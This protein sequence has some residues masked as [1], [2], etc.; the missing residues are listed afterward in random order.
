MNKDKLLIL[1]ER[2]L[3]NEATADEIKEIDAW[4][5]QFDHE[6]DLDPEVLK[7]PPPLVIN[8]FCKIGKAD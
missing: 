3:A 6:P 2:Y 8:R 1:I 4:Y 7:T 5:D